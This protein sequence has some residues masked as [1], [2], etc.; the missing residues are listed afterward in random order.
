M[1]LELLRLVS[2]PKKN[3][4]VNKVVGT[5]LIFDKE[6]TEMSGCRLYNCI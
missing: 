5:W 3:G 2:S 4:H 1:W 6:L